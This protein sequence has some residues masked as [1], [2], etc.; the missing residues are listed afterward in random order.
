MDEI[1]AINQLNH[2]PSLYFP[3]QYDPN[4]Q[5]IREG[6]L[7]LTWSGTNKKNAKFVDKKEGYVY[8]FNDGN[9][10]HNVQTLLSS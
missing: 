8:L 4:R 9:I 1:V 5:W 7:R 6:L 10:P 3:L 2:R